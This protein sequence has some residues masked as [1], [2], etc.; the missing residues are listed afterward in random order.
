MSASPDPPLPARLH[1]HVDLLA[2][3]IGPRHLGKPKALSAAAG[4]IEKQFA[5]AGYA[6]AKETYVASGREVSNLIA[7]ISGQARPGE[8]LILGAHY[9]TVST[10]PGA[11]D[12]ASAVAALL[13]TARLLHDAQPRRTIRFVAF[14]CEE[15]P[16]FHLGEMG[17]QHHA[18]RCHEQGENI[19]GMLC[20]EMVGY[21]TDAPRSQAAPPGIPPLLQRFFPTRG[22]FL[23]AVG[24]LRSWRLLW[25]FRRGFR[26]GSRLPLWTLPMPESIPEI[27]LSDNASFWDQGYPALMITDTS[28]F[29]NPH[30]H[31]ASDTPATLAYEKL[32]EV[33]EG[34]TAAVLWIAKSKVRPA[35]RWRP[36]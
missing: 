19:V 15:P 9:D 16:H 24:N 20:L 13:E 25:Q 7:E 2:G 26:R 27:R 31:L 1:Q 22:N 5:E 8:I 3:V 21:F 23:A 35:K 30:Y 33:V 14:A 17:S 34:V 10:T 4:Y 6:V 11:D 28:F 32:A 29:R 18:R 36:R 12:N